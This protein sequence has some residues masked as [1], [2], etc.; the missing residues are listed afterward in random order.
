V[1]KDARLI[2]NSRLLVTVVFWGVIFGVHSERRTEGVVLWELG[3]E[4]D[5]LG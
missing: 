5:I 1:S 2:M 4:G 3:A